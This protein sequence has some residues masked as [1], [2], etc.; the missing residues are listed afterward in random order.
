MK[1]IIKKLFLG[2]ISL[3]FLLA[4]AMWL[5]LDHREFTLFFNPLPS[6]EK[7]IAHFQAHR[8]E[9]ES[10]AIKYKAFNPSLG[11]G[12][13]DDLPGV[14]ELKQ[15]AA[16]R[17]VSEIGA[18]WFPN[19]YSSDASREFEAQHKKA[20]FNKLEHSHPYKSIR[21]TL[22]DQ[23]LGRRSRAIWLPSIWFLRWAWKD[24]FYIPEIPKI[25]KGRL[26]YPVTPHGNSTGSS[27][28]YDSLNY[29]PFWWRMGECVYRQFEPHWLLRMC[30]AA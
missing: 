4:V 24:Y 19:P 10:L 13:F 8:A 16:I 7:M 25:E 11:T 6:D 18:T 3:P 28:A 27:R 29:Y 14:K 26:W 5:Y 22:E 21:F 12:I 20:G 30:T 9:F 17:W 23:P 1:S 15:K 2:L